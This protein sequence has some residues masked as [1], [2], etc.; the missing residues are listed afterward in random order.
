MRTALAVRGPAGPPGAG[1][2]AGGTAGQFLVKGSATDFDTD[3][4]S[5]AANLPAGMVTPPAGKWAQATMLGNAVA[6]ATAPTASIPEAMAMPV[7]RGGNITGVGFYLGSAGT[8]GYALRVTLYDADPT[9]WLPRNAVRELGTY[10]LG[11]GTGD[12]A[13]TFSSL[14]ITAQLYWLV[15]VVQGT[16]TLPNMQNSTG[17]SPFV[18]NDGSG[19]NTDVARYVFPAVASGPLPSPMTAPTGTAA[20]GRRFFVWGA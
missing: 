14:A 17:S 4:M 2:A 8:S 7:V 20:N 6:T 11:A 1:I 15:Y 5:V 13:I 19:F 3:W 18:F 16:G 9:T 10:T 12:K